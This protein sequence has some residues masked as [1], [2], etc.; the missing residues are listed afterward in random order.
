MPPPPDAY[1]PDDTPT[2]DAPSAEEVA[3]WLDVLPGIVEERDR[4]AAPALVEIVLRARLDDVDR[5]PF[6]AALGSLED[7]RV[8]PRLEQVLRDRTA[9]RPLRLAALEVLAATPLRDRGPDQVLADLRSRDDLIQAHGYDQLDA[10][11]ADWIP[12]GASSRS[13]VVRLH[14]VDA[15]CLLSRT[16]PL[17][18]VLRRALV[19]PAPPVREAACRAAYFDEPLA[20]GFALTER[21]DDDDPDVR[22]A[23]HLALEEYP[24]VG[25]LL[26]L[27]DLAGSSNDEGLAEAT[28]E[29]LVIRIWMA[30]RA[31]D[32]TVRRHVSEWLRPARWLVDEV[33]AAWDPSQDQLSD[34]PDDE[35][36]G[37]IAP[38]GRASIAG[39]HREVIEG[40]LDP[41]SSPDLLRLVLLA[42]DWTDADEHARDVLA[43]C[44]RSERW[45]LR[46]LCCQALRD[47]GDL[48]ALLRAAG[49]PEGTIRGA[50]LVGLASSP[51]LTDE[52]AGDALQR[53]REALLDPWAR[54]VAGDAALAVLTTHGTRTEAARALVDELSR[55]EDRDGLFHGALA[56][57]RRMRVEEA[58]PALLAIVS[59]PVYASVHSHVGA[60]RALRTL[61]HPRDRIHLRHLRGVDHLAVQVEL[62][63]WG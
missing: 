31:G 39:L 52:Q 14:A 16:R 25:V 18:E 12:R 59:A 48:E 21:L 49:D 35:D 45:E 46:G 36:T 8:V 1:D 62:A 23:A 19:D 5:A 33:I 7:V 44:A 50:A 20:L 29:T 57:V 41:D 15:A 17:V 6:V 32:A 38:E 60:L 43:A 63:H 30:L 10:P 55:A 51:D 40:V 28:L 42:H 22:A 4:R 27:G 53:A 61:G 9:P 2:R 58:V 24:Q 37:P 26:A 47:T 34:G 54:P 56:A 3:R 13:A 11:L